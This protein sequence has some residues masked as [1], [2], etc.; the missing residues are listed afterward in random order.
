MLSL[1]YCFGTR[2]FNPGKE[3]KLTAE[4]QGA[5]QGHWEADTAHSFQG[6]KEEP[7]TAVLT[8]FS[9][10]KNAWQKRYSELPDKLQHG[11]KESSPLLHFKQAII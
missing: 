8:S 2:R 4:S 6:S 5:E 7:S 3:L 11:W 9:Q 10:R 1:R